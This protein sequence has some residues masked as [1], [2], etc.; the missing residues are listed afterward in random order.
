MTMEINVTN[1]SLNYENHEALHNISFHC[2]QKKVYG[3]LGRNGAGKSTLLKIISSRVFPDSGEISINGELDYGRDSAQ[4]QIYLMGEENYYPKDM[5]IKEIFKW[6][7]AFYP[8]FDMDYATDLAKQFKLDI[9][10]RVKGLSTGYSTLFKVIVALAVNTP[11]TLLDE[12]ILGLDANHRDLFYRLLLESYE[13]NPR[14][15]VISTHLIEEVANIIEDIIIIKDGSVLKNISCEELVGSGYTI[16]GKASI[17][18][19]YM[20]DK[21][22]IGQ[23]Q[24]GSLKSAYILGN[25]NK[26]P[27]PSELE[28]TKLDLQKL[29]I[30]LT[31]E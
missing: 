25:M 3:L 20:K 15:L 10:K 19:E 17:V 21:E 31:N 2:E 5:K 18:D 14:T 7:Q 26:A 6:S 1:L 4:R 28:V 11:Y 27:V 13:N 8:N 9:N 29:F 12:P 16:S 23:D 24:I 30:E 22:V